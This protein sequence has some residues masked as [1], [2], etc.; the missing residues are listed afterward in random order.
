MDII[1]Y[2]AEWMAFNV[3]LALLPILFA[4]SF[5]RSKKSY[6]KILFFILWLLFV[7]NTIYLVTDLKYFLGDFVNVLGFYKLIIALQYIVLFIFGIITFILALYPFDRILSRK[8]S[9]FR[10]N[11]NLLLILLNLIIA[12]GVSLGRI[13]RINSWDIFINPKAVIVAGSSLLKLNENLMAVLIFGT[14]SSLIYFT[15]I[16]ILKDK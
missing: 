2:N 8:K 3:F 6:F 7:P 16:R 12:F 13:E 10:Q 9:Q 11:R 14:F 1:L 4:F 5:L 15:A